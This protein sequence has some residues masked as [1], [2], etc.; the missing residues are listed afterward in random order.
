MSKKINEVKNQFEKL[1]NDLAN[2]AITTNPK[3]LKKIS[4][5]YSRLEPIIKKIQELEKVENE[6]SQSFQIKNNKK[7]N[8]AKS[9]KKS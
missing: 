1:K 3:N 8:I 9:R 5:E 6:V 4:Q 2:P 7:Y